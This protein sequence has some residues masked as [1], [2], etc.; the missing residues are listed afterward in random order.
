MRISDLDPRSA[1]TVDGSE[2]LRYAA[3]HLADDDIGVL[4][5]FNASGLVGI[6]SER[7]LAR[8][9]ADGADLDEEQVGEYM[10]DSP[11]RVEVG[12]AV[13]TAI[14]KMNEFSV[15][16]LV[17]VNGGDVV[18]MLSMRDLIALLGTAWPEL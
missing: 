4:A 2:S 12:D 10:T 6:L 15:R 18:G 5:V 1:I 14:A 13:G 3:K 17:V 11:V 9:V 16:H 8:A 7:D